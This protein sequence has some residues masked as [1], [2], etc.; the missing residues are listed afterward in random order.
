MDRRGKHV[1]CNPA[2]CKAAIRDDDGL[3]DD[4]YMEIK[5][6]FVRFE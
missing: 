2:D 4:G 1:D 6:V 5:P 3:G